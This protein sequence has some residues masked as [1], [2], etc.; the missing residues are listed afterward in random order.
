MGDAASEWAADTPTVI[1]RHWL[2]VAAAALSV[3][4]VC[5]DAAG[6]IDGPLTVSFAGKGTIA[7]KAE[8][9]VLVTVT[10][11]ALVNQTDGSVTVSLSQDS[12]PK[13]AAGRGSADIVCDGNAHSYS[14]RVFATTGRWHNGTG[15]AA[16]TGVA[17]GY[18]T[19][20]DCNGDNTICVT[21]NVPAE[22]AGAGGPAT[23]TLDNG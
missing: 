17:D 10:C 6:A 15:S 4:I 7:S 3:S 21:G 18:V 5:A 20:T 1:R 19:V 23:I 16:A 22:D 2:I 9:D 14:V 13:Q 11:A 8:A 12:G